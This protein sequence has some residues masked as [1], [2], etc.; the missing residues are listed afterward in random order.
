MSCTARRPERRP[1][2]ASRSLA[3]RPAAERRQLAT[4]L[5]LDDLFKVASLV[6][7]AVRCLRSAAGRP[8]RKRLGLVSLHIS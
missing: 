7:A 5:I 2:A 3:G 6:A 8:T 1:A 4:A